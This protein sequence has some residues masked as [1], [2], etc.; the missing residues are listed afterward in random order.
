MYSDPI[1]LILCF[2]AS[3]VADQS[4]AIKRIYKDMKNED[5]E[6]ILVNFPYLIKLV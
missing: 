2:I 4:M 5:I 1:G 6:K 3:L